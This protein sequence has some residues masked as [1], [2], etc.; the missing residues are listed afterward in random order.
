MILR[1]AK[2]WLSHDRQ[3]CSDVR[4]SVPEV[5]AIQAITYMDGIMMKIGADKSEQ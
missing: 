5:L 3:D 2:R 4:F 1:E